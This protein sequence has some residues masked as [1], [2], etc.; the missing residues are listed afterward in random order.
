MPRPTALALL[1]AGVLIA[2]QSAASPQLGL[3]LNAL[4]LGEVSADVVRSLSALNV[5]S[6]FRP[7]LIADVYF[8]ARIYISSTVKD[9]ST[10]TQS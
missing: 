3:D 7:I 1:F 6:R 8:V 9:C 4:G 5:F 2:T 10:F